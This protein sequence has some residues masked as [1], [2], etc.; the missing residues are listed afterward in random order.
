MVDVIETEPGK[1]AVEFAFAGER[2]Q[3]ISVAGSFNDWDPECA[4]MEFDAA[5]GHFRRRVDLPAGAYEYKFVVDGR[6]M[7]DDSNPN[8]SANDFGTLNSVLN[9]GC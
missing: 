9:L 1:F 8:F 4:P 3:R 7:L 6:W 2:S 5:S